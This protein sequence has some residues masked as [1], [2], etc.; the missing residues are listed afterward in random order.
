MAKRKPKI[1]ELEHCASIREYEASVI[2][3]RK[4]AEL[5]DDKECVCSICGRHRWKFL[6]RVK[7]WKRLLRFSVHHKRYDNV[8]NEAPDDLIVVCYMCHDTAHLLLRLSEWL[9]PWKRIAEIIREYFVYEGNKG[10]K[11]W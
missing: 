4:S 6:P 7:K 5:L 9:G 8:P 3:K 1:T 10:F 11:P 2:W